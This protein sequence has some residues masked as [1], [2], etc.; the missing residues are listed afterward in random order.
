MRDNMKFFK[1][2]VNSS[3]EDIH[4]TD[5]LKE[6]TLNKCKKENRIRIRPTYVAGICAVFIAFATTGYNYL[7]PNKIN[8]K[9]SLNISA[10]ERQLENLGNLIKN[11]IINP[12]PNNA[13]LKNNKYA[14]DKKYTKKSAKSEDLKNANKINDKI[15]T[16]L[17]NKDILNPEKD[18]TAKNDKT[19]DKIESKDEQSQ[20]SYD[21]SKNKQP[22][23]SENVSSNQIS[24]EKSS[25]DKSETV[26]KNDSNSISSISPH[27]MN[28]NSVENSFGQKVTTPSYI[29]DGFKLINI[30]IPDN[31]NEKFV[32][33]N[34]T[35]KDKHFTIRQDRNIDF[36][37][38]I[39]EKLY[40]TGIR[41]YSS[42]VENC[43]ELRIALNKDN[44][45]YVIQGNISKDILI[46]IIGS[47]N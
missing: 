36:N 33:M 14:Y 19:E 15:D 25:S 21:T 37:N 24:T 28:M 39:G 3:L 27:L 26:E 47:M 16:N 18:S 35:F 32:K 22:D 11:S 30:T 4:V 7:F 34:Y 43:S 23:E 1:D 9:Y 41:A 29:P 6:K 44:I 20:I 5:E 45:Q 17:K 40:I 31:D 13:T 12:S 38:N 2:I 46:S 10:T 8:K 42:W